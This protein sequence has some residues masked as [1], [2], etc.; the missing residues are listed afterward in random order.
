MTPEN[1]L[2]SCKMDYL[3]KK[4]AD[5]KVVEFYNKSRWAITPAGMSAAEVE[6]QF[7]VSSLND[8]KFVSI[9]PSAE[10]DVN[11][12]EDEAQVYTTSRVWYQNKAGKLIGVQVA[13]AT[14]LIARKVVTSSTH[15][16]FLNS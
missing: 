13:R 15:N 8:L 3:V 14:T 2:E 10:S 12:A 1:Y 16:D 4:A 5:K 9:E 7:G 11:V 6:A